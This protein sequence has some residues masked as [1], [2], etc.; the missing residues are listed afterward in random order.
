M[1]LLL[2]T[3]KKQGHD[4]LRAMVKSGIPLRESTKK[5]VP[6]VLP[7]PT[8]DGFEWHRRKRTRRR[9]RRRP[10]ALRLSS[11]SLTMRR[12]EAAIRLL[13]DPT[14]AAA[15]AASDG[16]PAPA[17]V[18][19]GGGEDNDDVGD[20]SESDAGMRGG[21][22]GLLE[23]GGV[24]AVESRKWLGLGWLLV[25]DWRFRN[26][27]L[28]QEVESAGVRALERKR[29][30]MRDFSRKERETKLE[31]EASAAEAWVDRD[32]PG[33]SGGGGGKMITDDR[34]SRLVEKDGPPR[35]GLDLRPG[36]RRG[37]NE[38][39]SLW[40]RYQ[41]TPGIVGR[42]TQSRSSRPEQ[43][44]PRERGNRRRRGGGGGGG[45]YR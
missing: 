16:G 11:S 22:E 20:R 7:L 24:A 4:V 45:Q 26:S 43:Q 39:L 27:E 5:D 15:T 23:D 44:P 12:R 31:D 41:R 9:H 29:Q 8:G 28:R 30:R 18:T 32:H 35:T 25:S 17:Y 1:F 10:I 38:A 33:T 2:L 36:G 37:R 14:A 34:L 19:P 3:R 6:S 42:G 21:G 40:M 13:L